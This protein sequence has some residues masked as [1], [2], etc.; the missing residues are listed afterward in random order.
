MTAAR[1]GAAAAWTMETRCASRASGNLQYEI[2]NIRK[3][4]AAGAFNPVRRRACTVPPDVCLTSALFFA[5]LYYRTVDCYGLSISLAPLAVT[6]PGCWSTTN[7]YLPQTCSQGSRTWKSCEWF[8]I[9]IFS[10]L[11]CF[12]FCRSRAL[13]SNNVSMT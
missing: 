9:P 1:R 11:I 2:K 3:R 7:W 10:C 13:P 5:P 8:D 4:L 6:R 12:C